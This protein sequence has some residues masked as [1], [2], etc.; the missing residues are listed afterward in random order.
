MLEDLGY[1]AFDAWV[2][3]SLSSDGPLPNQPAYPADA[4]GTLP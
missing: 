3:M 4:A 2:R 1:T